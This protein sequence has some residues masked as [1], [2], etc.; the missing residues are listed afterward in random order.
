M[1]AP[2]Q[3]GIV[4]LVV[5]WAIRHTAEPDTVIGSSLETFMG[6]LDCGTP[7]RWGDEDPDEQPWDT[8]NMTRFIRSQMPHPAHVLIEGGPDNP[9]M[10]TMTV[11][12]TRHGVEEVVTG[13]LDAGPWGS[14]ESARRVDKVVEALEKMCDGTMPLFAS[15]MVRGAWGL[16]AGPSTPMAPVAMLIGPPGVRELGLDVD[17]L[18]QQFGA[19]AAG[20]PRLPALV[21]P[22][23]STD[24]PGNVRL[25]RI[26]TAIGEDKIRSVLG[27]D[28]QP[29]Q[30][31]VR[32]APYDR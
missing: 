8:K 17:G 29:T 11:D 30:K 25:A 6:A 32:D 14:P 7:F 3:P 13:F 19:R 23:L 28:E 22:L 2:I 9:A 31:E 21:F 10:L 1:T 16:A 24:E 15:V 5:S 27:W 20:R 12:R 4:Q 26:L 18:C